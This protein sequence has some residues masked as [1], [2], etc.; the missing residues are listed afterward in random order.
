MSSHTCTASVSQAVLRSHGVLTDST[1]GFSTFFP[2]ESQ[3]NSEGLSSPRSDRRPC[4]RP[5][6]TADDA[7]S[8]NR[9]VSRGEIDAPRSCSRKPIRWQVISFTASRNNRLPRCLA[10]LLPTARGDQLPFYCLLAAVG[11]IA[12]RLHLHGMVLESGLENLCVRDV[13]GLVDECL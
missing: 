1:G 10:L 6:P 2:D 4:R 3:V 5:D 13:R 8:W 9:T 11:A 12:Q 7:G